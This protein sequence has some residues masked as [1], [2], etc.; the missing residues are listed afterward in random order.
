MA[1]APATKV[2][3]AMTN[4]LFMAQN[5][6]EERAITCRVPIPL[7]VSCISTDSTHD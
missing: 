5:Q 3:V 7:L 4:L 1:I 6:C 2:D